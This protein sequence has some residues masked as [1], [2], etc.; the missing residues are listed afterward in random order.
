MAPTTESFALPRPMKNSK[1]SK[2]E[3]KSTSDA[4]SSN[5]GFSGV[6]P[7]EKSL[8]NSRDKN[9][10]ENN[11]SNDSK[12]E[13]VRATNKSQVNS[14]DKN[15]EVVNIS[16]SSKIDGVEKSHANSFRELTKGSFGKFFIDFVGKVIPEI[17][18]ELSKVEKNENSNTSDNTSEEITSSLVEESPE[19]KPCP[20]EC[21]FLKAL[22]KSTLPESIKNAVLSAYE[23]KARI[24]NQLTS[25]DIKDNF[26]NRFLIG[27]LSDI[28]SE[29]K[30]CSKQ[31]N[32]SKE[33][34]Y[35]Y[36]FSASLKS[37]SIAEAKEMIK[38]NT[39]ISNEIFQAIIEHSLAKEFSIILDDFNNLEIVDSNFDNDTI[40]WKIKR[41]ITF[42]KNDGK[43]E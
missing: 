6:P 15:I 30:K 8:V 25:L 4:S 2:I 13:E 42:A 40:S 21:K 19:N 31:F 18:E 29:Y 14:C 27:K 34:T 38:I 23:T 11:T 17:S 41:T 28:E 9:I 16:D 3:E 43:S 7:E 26:H 33:V 37:I 24:V 35:T 32:R 1:N 22:E 20:F 36:H 5:E 39:P 12:I 10:E